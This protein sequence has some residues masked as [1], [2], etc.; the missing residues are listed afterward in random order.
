MVRL[1]VHMCVKE[2]GRGGT[3]EVG[4]VVC[5]HVCGRKGEGG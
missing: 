5:A 3:C 1:C 2:R 4:E